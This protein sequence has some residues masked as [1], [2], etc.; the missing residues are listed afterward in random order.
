[1]KSSSTSSPGWSPRPSMGV[2]GP[3]KDESFGLPAEGD[4]CRPRL[5]LTDGD[6]C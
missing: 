2:D 4:D 6:D 1:M 5:L 3:G